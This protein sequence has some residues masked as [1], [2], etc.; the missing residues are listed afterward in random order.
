MICDENY[1]SIEGKCVEEANGG[2][3]GNDD[4]TGNIILLTC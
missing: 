4:S 2:E 3:S 1:E